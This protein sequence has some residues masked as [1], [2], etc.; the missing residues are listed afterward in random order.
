MKKEKANN[1]MYAIYSAGQSVIYLVVP[2]ILCL[3]AGIWLD[4]VLHTTPWLL[5]IGVV[6]GFS[7]GL[8][9]VYKIMTR[10]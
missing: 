9:N 6:L 1:M 3:L 7:T 2:V 10:I 5:I 8:W 4:S